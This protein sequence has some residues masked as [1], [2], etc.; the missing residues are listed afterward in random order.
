MLVSGTDMNTV[1]LSDAFV[2]DLTGDYFLAL[3]G[4]TEDARNLV[5]SSIFLGASLNPGFK[6]TRYFLYVDAK[7]VKVLFWS[8]R[9]G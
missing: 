4:L 8:L 2:E 6:N 3:H 1:W 5:M 9:A 7:H